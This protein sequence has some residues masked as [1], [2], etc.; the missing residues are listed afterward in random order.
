MGARFPRLDSSCFRANRKLGS[1]RQR[2]RTFLAESILIRDGHYC[3]RRF[4]SGGMSAV[5]FI[6]ENQIKFFGK[7][8]ALHSVVDAVDD[9]RSVA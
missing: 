8:G 1:R 9:Q 6:E 7:E 2:R 5:W 3:G 4:E